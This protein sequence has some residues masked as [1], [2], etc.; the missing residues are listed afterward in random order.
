MAIFRQSSFSPHFTTE[1]SL[2]TADVPG[3][4]VANPPQKVFKWREPFLSIA[5]TLFEGGHQIAP[6][7]NLLKSRLTIIPRSRAKILE[8]EFDEVKMVHS[9]IVL[10]SIDS[11]T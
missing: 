10:R 11:T 2:S 7:N 5:P 4:T 6:F 8:V 3:N 9:S 1:K